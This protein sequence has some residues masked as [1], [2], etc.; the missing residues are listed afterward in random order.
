M[1]EKPAIKIGHLKIMDHLILGVTDLKVTK[2]KEKF[3]HCSLELVLNTG[4]MD[5]ADSLAWICP[6][7]R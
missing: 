1:A 4:W 3:D 6:M 2:G 7:R 5:V